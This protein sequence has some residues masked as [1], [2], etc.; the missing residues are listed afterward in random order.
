[1]RNRDEALE[2]LTQYSLQQ[3]NIM[4][5]IKVLSKY[6]NKAVGVLERSRQLKRS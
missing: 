1:M 6:R 4:D 5:A 2:I 3:V